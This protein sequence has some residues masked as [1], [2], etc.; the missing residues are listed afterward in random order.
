[1]PGGRD[2]LP[3]GRDDS[4]GPA[5]TRQRQNAHTTASTC[6]NLRDRDGHQRTP[7]W[8]SNLPRRAVSTPKLI[9]T[10]SGLGGRLLGV[11]SG[12]V[13]AP[14]GP[15]LENFVTGEMARQLTWADEP[16]QLF[17]YRD[18]DQVEVDIVLE[19]ATTS[20]PARAGARSAFLRSLLLE[21]ER[22]LAGLGLDGAL[23]LQPRRVLRLDLVDLGG[24]ERLGDAAPGQP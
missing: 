9:V 2:L 6:D 14:V 13:T 23:V 12:D 3:Y 1:M 22:L 5:L 4:R 21:A 19:H 18:R 16:V 7:A 11:S 20:A 8:S 15:L 17:H 10:D 24:G